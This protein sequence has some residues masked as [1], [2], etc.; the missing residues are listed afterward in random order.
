M[1]TIA[2]EEHFRSQAVRDA[3]SSGLL[4]QLESPTLGPVLQKLDDVDEQRIADLD[5]TGIDVQV[6]S[7]APVGGDTLER[8]DEHEL[9]RRI[10]DE[11]AEIMRRHADRYAGFATL[12]MSD[13]EGAAAEFTRAISELGMRGAMV[14]GTTNGRFLDDRSFVPVLA[15]AEQLH[16]PI[17]IHPAPP[18]EPIRRSYYEG[19]APDVSWVLATSGWG[20]H[21]ETGLHVLRLVLSGAFDRYPGLQVIIGHAGE[22]LPFMLARTNNVLGRFTKLERPP[23]DYFVQNVHYTISA[24][25]TPEPLRCLMDVIGVDRVMFAVDYPFSANEAGSNFIRS[26]PISDSDREKITHINA[27]ALLGV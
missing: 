12:P 13:P 25:F 17:Y 7:H 22:A 19:F 24:F 5:A 18:P 1:R 3:L 16:V 2:L 4:R 27:E 20:W 21:I 26:A 15:T 9:V 14:H 23:R 8:R 11:L 10:N 6:L